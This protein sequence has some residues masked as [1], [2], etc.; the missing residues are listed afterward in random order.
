MEAGTVAGSDRR[1]S[2]RSLNL[3]VSANRRATATIGA[4]NEDGEGGG[5]GGRGRSHRS[6]ARVLWMVDR[7]RD[8][9]GPVEGGAAHETPPIARR[10]PGTVSSAARRSR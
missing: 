9:V 7:H 6:D 1:F 5:A 4:G 8:G 3:R 10:G 2:S